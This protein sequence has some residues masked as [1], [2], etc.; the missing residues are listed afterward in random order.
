MT[1]PGDWTT[2]KYLAFLSVWQEYINAETA[3]IN[4]INVRPPRVEG[5]I[6]DHW[7]AEFVRLSEICNKAAETYE[8]AHYEFLSKEH[9][10]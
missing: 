2:A 7:R 5:A 9:G 4:H 3:L 10:L 6:L 8:K 1:A